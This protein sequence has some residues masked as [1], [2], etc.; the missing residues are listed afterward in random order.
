MTSQTSQ[1]I[2][3]VADSITN[4]SSSFY[5]TADDFQNQIINN[6]AAEGF[7]SDE[8]VTIG[9]LMRQQNTGAIL[10]EN[11]GI[12]YIQSLAPDMYLSLTQAYLEQGKFAQKAFVNTITESSQSFGSVKIGEA[13]GNYI[14]TSLI[15]TTTIAPNKIP[16]LAKALGTASGALTIGAGVFDT[17][18][19]DNFESAALKNYLAISAGAT[20]AVIVAPVLAGIGLTG[21]AAVAV[22]TV[23][24]GLVSTQIDKKWENTD[25]NAIAADIKNGV[26]TATEAAQ[27]LSNDIGDA[28]D[29][30]W[31]LTGQEAVDLLENSKEA[32]EDIADGIRGIID[33]YGWAAENLDLLA[34]DIPDWAQG[35]LDEQE[36]AETLIDRP[37]L[38]GDPLVLDLNGNGIELSNADGADAVYWDIDVDG[39]NEKS[40][41][42]AGGDGLL[43]IDTNNDGIINDHTELFGDQTG[44]DNG[45]LALTQ[46][47]SNN[48]GSITTADTDFSNLLVWV[49]DNND[50]ISQSA[51]LYTLS[52]LGITSIN[53]NYAEVDYEISANPV[54]QESTFVMNGQTRTIVDAYFAF[55]NIN[56]QFN[57]T[58]TDYTLDVRT[59]FLPT[60]RG[61]GNL[62]DLHIAMSQDETLLNM[63]QDFSVQDS[64]SLLSEA[65]DLE[66]KM[67]EILYQ[68]AGV[69]NNATDSR[70]PNIDA[71]T[72]EFFEKFTGEEWN[73]GQNPGGNA[74]NAI[75]NNFESAWS[76]FASQI[77]AQTE[78]KSFLGKQAIIK[79]M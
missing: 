46:L 60:L 30:M 21:L 33:D 2:L 14:E 16:N 68:W 67:T 5:L 17:I 29:N 26:V 37:R 79:Y 28:L 45:F 66:S 38:G 74:S 53:L 27:Q 47:D 44:F 6:L 31:D 43:A 62:P 3:N 52:Q 69:T 78:A 58:N 19:S 32:Y 41:W 63:V 40:G 8:Q 25:F 61:F 73:N 51:E 48:D 4:N 22:A 70:G 20:A 59:L 36:R 12:S 7:T 15:T 13:V 57:D 10:Q 54:L 75:I 77:M 71:R 9:E 56:T 34:S 76:I 50:A 24:G 11:D 23:I 39:F 64:T 72:L 49:D 18:Q 65:Y 1:G 55:S 35:L 42:I